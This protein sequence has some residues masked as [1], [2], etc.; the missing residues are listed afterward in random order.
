MAGKQRIPLEA[1]H[2]ADLIALWGLPA[3]KRFL[4]RIA[5]SADMLRFANG[6]EDRLLH[7][8][9]RLLGFE[10]YRWVGEAI[11]DSNATDIPISVLLDVLQVAASTPGDSNAPQRPSF[12]SE[13]EAGFA[14][15]EDQ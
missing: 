1:L 14:G 10:I 2:Q 15:D 5:D 13:R 11:S 7:E 3:F 4:F 8:G 12:A 9:R 6:S